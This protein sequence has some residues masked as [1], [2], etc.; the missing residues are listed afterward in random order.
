LAQPKD[1]D[2]VDCRVVE[3]AAGRLRAYAWR[4][5]WHWYTGM[6]ERDDPGALAIAE[7]IA[8]GPD[9]ADVVL[10]ACRAWASEESAGRSEPLKQVVLPMAPDSSVAAA[11]MH[12]SA[13]FD[14]RYAPCG[15]SMA[16]L[17]DVGRLLEAL[18]PELAQ[19]LADAGTPYRG[20]V[21]FQTELGSA[22]LDVGAEG[23]L[24]V[25]AEPGERSSSVGSPSAAK[26]R[27]ADP[28]TLRLPQATLARLSLGAFPP[29]D[30]IARLEEPLPEGAQ[31]LIRILFPLLH[32]HMYLPDRY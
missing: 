2:E 13:R 19:R 8:D 16:R 28:L 18:K 22:L 31:R 12:Q 3:D 7:V 9:S 5:R 30:L 32:P 26:Q 23:T 4:A 21:Q 25:R 14:Q 11:A 1:Q 24:R 6:V 27:N 29:E 15:S 20:T 10:A 17:L